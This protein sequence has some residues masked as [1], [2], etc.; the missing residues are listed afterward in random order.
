MKKLL[1]FGMI[2]A[3]AIAFTACNQKTETEK[4]GEYE[5][6]EQGGKF[7]LK[8]DGFTVLSPVYDDIREIEAYQCIFAQ[9]DAET[10]IVVNGNAIFTGEINLIKNAS[11]VGYYT[12]AT[13]KGKYLWKAQS[14]YII[15]AFEDIVMDGDIA[16]LKSAEGWGATFTDHTPIAPRRF[17][18]VYVV[19]NGNTHAVLVYTTKKGWALY[20]K[21]GV[22]DG[23]KY[24]IPSKELEKQLTKF[25]ISK[26]Y[27]VLE[28][29]WNL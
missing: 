2:I 1:F 18:K 27:G 19:N 21:D 25:D 10:T 3:I 15:G 4:I 28:T 7:G 14:S 13:P 22:S 16:F 8:L 6:I 12:I 24:D 5:L 11:T 26:P 17:E 23:L 29:N 9:K 20:D